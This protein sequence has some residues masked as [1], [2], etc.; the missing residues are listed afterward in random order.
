MRSNEL[1][2]ARFVPETP[3]SS[4]STSVSLPS[5]L[6]SDAA[7]FC[8]SRP[9]LIRFPWLRGI[10]LK[11]G[12]EFSRTHI[13]S[14]G[15]FYFRELNQLLQET[16]ETKEAERLKESLSWRQFLNVWQSHLCTPVMFLS[17]PQFMYCSSSCSQM[18]L[19]RCI[20]LSVNQT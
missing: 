6:L 16:K 17:C 1:D 10:V 8:H 14:N 18:L 9:Q 5:C 3:W 15:F 12:G 20:Y 11:A 7:L 2:W 13:S 4:N 19:K